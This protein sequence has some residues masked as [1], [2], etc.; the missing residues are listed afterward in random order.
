MKTNGITLAF[1]VGSILA[2]SNLAQVTT[3]VP[4]STPDRINHTAVWTAREMIVW[5]GDNHLGAYLNSGGRFDPVSNRWSA[6]TLTLAP[7]ARSRHSA[8]WT[9]SE[10]IIWGG[11]KLESDRS[12]SPLN[13]GALYNPDSN[14]WRG[15]AIAGAPAPR[16]NHSAVWTGSEMI[17]WGGQRDFSNLN[18]GARYNPQSN[19]WTSI[20]TLNAPAAR[21]EHSAVWTGREMIVWGGGND[22][23]DEPVEGGRYNPVSDTWI[24]MTI[25]NSP[26]GRTGHAAVW[27]GS[28]LI[29]WGGSRLQD[30]YLFDGGRYDPESDRWTKLSESGAP[31]PGD[32]STTVWDGSEM[33]VWGGLYPPAGGF[34]YL[35]KGSRYNP[36]ENSWK[37]TTVVAA[38]TGRYFHTAV[39]TG[40]EM[41]I[42]GGTGKTAVS[43]TLGRYNP[44]AD[45]W[46]ILPAPPVPSLSFVNAGNSVHLFWPTD[47]IGVT[48]EFTD[49]LGMPSWQPVAGVSS[50]S[51]TLSD[52][53]GSGF[54]RLHKL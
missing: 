53:I 39:W 6:V 7:S 23:F 3:G 17:I 26:L 15:T 38:P 34:A 35:N 40:S 31:F 44:Q 21:S 50:N 9:G 46:T 33:I 4:P 49:N 47:T 52:A 11:F 45:S 42:W 41:I 2:Q 13:T 43:N 8:I 30:G 25:T 1:V 29:V 19:S 36:G 51:I 27:T 24:P 14:T 28:E 12:T 20:S 22:E 10:M 37:A 54:Y 16:S 48:L 5:G 32:G 18:T